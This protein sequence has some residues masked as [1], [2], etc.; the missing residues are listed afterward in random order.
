MRCL[1]A[2]RRWHPPGTMLL[3]LLHLVFLTPPPHDL[4]S[5]LANLLSAIGYFPSPTFRQ[6]CSHPRAAPSARSFP[7]S[8]P[9]HSLSCHSSQRPL[10][11]STCHSFQR[12]SKSPLHE[13]LIEHSQFLLLGTVSFLWKEKTGKTKVPATP[14]IQT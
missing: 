6:G 11:T 14:G 12:Q 10:R 2:N 3:L 4:P 5:V 8:G 1:P 9:P 7:H 13:L